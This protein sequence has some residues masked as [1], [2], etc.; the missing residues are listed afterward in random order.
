MLH[1]MRILAC[2][3]LM[4]AVCPQRLQQRRMRKAAV[5]LMGRPYRV[6]LTT[7][8]A[9]MS[10]AVM[11]VASAAEETNLRLK[12]SS[13]AVTCATAS[14]EFEHLS[15]IGSARTLIESRRRQVVD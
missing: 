14:A 10:T 12:A 11:C 1:L 8:A 9:A 13:A 4:T 6:A 5:I 3:Q 2:M 15:E 7:R